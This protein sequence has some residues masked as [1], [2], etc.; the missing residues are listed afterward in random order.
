MLI[1]RPRG[2]EIPESRV[3]PEAK[4]WNRRSAIA[5]LGGSAVI[6]AGALSLT[7]GEEALAQVAPDP[8]ANLYPARR[9]ARFDPGRAV[10]PEQIST[11]YNNFYEFG[12]HKQIWRAAQALPIRPWEV[13]IDG[14]VER[15]MTIAFDDLLRRV[16]LEERVHRFRCVEAW[17]MTIPWT[18]FTMSKLLAIANPTSA[19]RFIR[20]ETLH[21]PSVMP[22]QRQFWYPWPYVEGVSMDE[23]KNELALFVT[24]AYG[25]PLP[26][27]MG[28]PLRVILPWK[29]GFK[30]IKSITRIQFTA[31]RPRTFWEVT[32][33][34][35]YGF[36]ANV[37]PDVPHPRWSQASERLL[38]DGSRVPT[39]IYNGYGEWVAQL[40]RDMPASERVYM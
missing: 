31:E 14:L 29:Y 17:A 20:F 37:N 10:T 22:G 16:E 3:T 34:T 13:R 32:G 38:D 11:T 40:Y 30:S 18:G 25:K 15:P 39:R 26:R 23:A 28:A 9:D 4:F 36:W 21:N 12:S 5:A 2:W 27:Q 1:K 7:T 6:G 24:G 35:E 19:A 8:S 33:P